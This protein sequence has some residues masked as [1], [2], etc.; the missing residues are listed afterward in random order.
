MVNM[1]A[2]GDWPTKS[3]LNKGRRWWRAE[4]ASAIG[5]SIRSMGAAN[6]FG[7]AA[8]LRFLRGTQFAP[9]KIR[10]AADHQLALDLP[11]NQIADFAA[12]LRQDG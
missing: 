3:P 9:G 12:H 7:E 10:R 8:A 1:T 11:E 2:A 4:R 5:R 6:G